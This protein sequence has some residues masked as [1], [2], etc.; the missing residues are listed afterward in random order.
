MADFKNTAKSQ[1]NDN[2]NA[3][4]EYKVNKLFPNKNVFSQTE[5]DTIRS[6]KVVKAFKQL[7]NAVKMRNYDPENPPEGH[8]YDKHFKKHRRPYEGDPPLEYQNYDLL[9]E[10]KQKQRKLFKTH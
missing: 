1:C 8:K 6:K 3:F 5:I 4:Q 10:E 7:Q 2:L 9:V